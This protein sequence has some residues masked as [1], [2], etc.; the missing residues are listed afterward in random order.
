MARRVRDEKLRD[1]G[2]PQRRAVRASGSRE[3]HRW[4]KRC[5]M[6]PAQ[7]DRLGRT[8]DGTATCDFDPEEQ[9]R[10][11]SINVALA[12]CEWH[13]TK[14]NIVDVPGYLDFQG[15]VKSA[16]SVVEAAILVTPAQGEPEVGFENRLG[17]GCR[18]EICR[19][20]SSSTRWTVRTRTTRRSCRRCAPGTATSSRPSSCRSAPRRSSSGRDRSGGDEGVHRNRQ[21]CR[22][23]GD[24]A[25]LSWKKR[26]SIANCW[27]NPRPKA[28]TN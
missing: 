23:F 6:S 25:R 27:S 16:L 7:I 8:D 22:V 19:A 2:D 9:K 17:A 11:I 26:S 15:E 12:P 24:P 5:C 18:A 14:I 10:H 3:R 21:R 28:T 13:D 4:R 1:Q 20:P